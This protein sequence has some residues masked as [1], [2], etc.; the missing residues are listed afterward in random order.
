MR[1]SPTFPAG[2]RR[3]AS[4]PHAGPGRAHPQADDG[5]EAHRHPQQFRGHRKGEGDLAERLPVQRGGSETVEGEVYRVPSSQR[6]ASQP[7]MAKRVELRQPV[8]LNFAEFE[9]AVFA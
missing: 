3:W 4:A 2:Q 5:S 7:I 6:I 9:N 8:L 1:L